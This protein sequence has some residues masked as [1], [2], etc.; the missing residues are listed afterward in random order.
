M[1]YNKISMTKH[2]NMVE[3]ELV[4]NFKIAVLNNLEHHIGKGQQDATEYDYFLSV[5]YSVAELIAKRWILTQRRYKEIKPKRVYYL[6]MEF[7]MG[8]ALNNALINLDTLEVTRKALLELGLK[9]DEVEEL[10]QDAALGNGGLGRLAACFIDSLATLDIPCHGYGINYNFGLFNQEIVDGKQVEKPDNWLKVTSPWQFERPEYAVDI[11]F[12]GR[13]I[14]DMDESN[15]K[16]KRKWQHA[17][18]VIA[19]A[20]DTPIPGCDT[21]TVN[22]LRLWSARAAADFDFTFFNRG[23]YM[24]ASEQQVMSENISK[25][26]YP[27]DEADVGKEL[28]LK[29]EYFLVSAS[30]Q[31]IIRRFKA[32]NG[33]DFSLLPDKVAIQLNDTHPTLAIPELMRILVDI[34]SLEWHTAWEISQKVFGYTNHTVLPEAL[35]EWSVPLLTKL[36]PRHMEIIFLIN[37]FFMLDVSAFFVNN[38]DKMRSMSIIAEGDIQHVK[39]SHLA[40]VGSH[41]VNGVAEIHSKIIRETMFRDFY[42][43]MPQ[44]FANVTNGITQRRWLKSANPKLAELITEAIGDG[45]VKDLLQLTKLEEFVRDDNFK[46]EWRHVKRHNKIRLANE[47]EALTGTIISPTTIFDVQVKRIHEYKRQLLFALYEI[48]EYIRIKETGATLGPQTCIL[49]GKAAPGYRTAKLIIE[50]IN[51]VSEM[52]SRDPD[53]N[54]LLNVIFLPNYRVSLAEKIIPAADLSEQ[55][56]T[57]G[58]EASGTGNM[59]FALN[60]AITIGTLDGA[61]IEI[62]EHV[63]KENIFIFGSDVKRVN[64]LRH[65]GFNPPE[66]IERSPLLQKVLNLIETDFFSPSEPGL[67]RP[68][69]DILTKSDYYQITADFDAYIHAQD[70]AKSAYLNEDEWTKMSILNTARSGYF[71]SDRAVLEY[72]QNIWNVKAVELYEGLT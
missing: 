11:H 71:S 10:E 59:K 9:L 7:L 6:S 47:I 12:G 5:A 57:A 13:I 19:H 38:A 54:G 44:K 52:I 35:E 21:I 65:N 31:D 69:Y 23:D 50:F 20:S 67:F 63:G 16:Y 51:R 70:Q 33:D 40:I 43:M 39:M 46:E 3:Q 2:E 62:L 42:E 55:I 61:N 14:D 60:G 32:E 45:W 15:N 66:F 34:E 72:A 17:E 25:V 48:A 29:Q 27:S 24:R 1:W 49:G 68:L 64:E 22:T 58:M 8:R 4:E 18:T 41:K 28:R 53:C 30:V 56:S 36:L 37:H 26:L